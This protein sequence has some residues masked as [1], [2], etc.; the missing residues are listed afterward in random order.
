[1]RRVGLAFESFARFVHEN[2]GTRIECS[3]LVNVLSL[4]QP[5]K[6]GRRILEAAFESCT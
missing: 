4:Q 6:I 5:M 3:Q 2:R 1:M